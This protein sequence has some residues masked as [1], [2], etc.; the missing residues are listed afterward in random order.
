MKQN[1]EQERFDDNKI[2]EKKRRQHSFTM[3]ILLKV[4]KI[5][6][7]IDVVGSNTQINNKYKIF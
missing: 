1:N 5:L 6:R 7:Y 4:E 2:R 3:T